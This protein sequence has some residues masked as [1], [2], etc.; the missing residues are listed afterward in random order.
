[1]EL[2]VGV[3]IALINLMRIA[4]EILPSLINTAAGG[5][6]FGMLSCSVQGFL[7]THLFCQA[8]YS[9]TVRSGSLSSGVSCFFL[10]KEA[11]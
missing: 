9:V 5:W 2:A 3:H 4:V 8:S 11:C 7:V 1:M 10:S 6:V